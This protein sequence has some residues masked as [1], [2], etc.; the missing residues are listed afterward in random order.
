MAL[1]LL[2]VLLVIRQQ[3][4]IKGGETITGTMKFHRNSL[5]HME[6]SI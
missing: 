5:H 6:R 3:I 2:A 4:L 1:E